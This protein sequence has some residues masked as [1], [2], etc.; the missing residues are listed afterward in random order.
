MNLE[1]SAVTIVASGFLDPSQ[2]S[3]G[4]EF[5]LYAALAGGGQLIELPKIETAEAQI[6]HNSGD[7]AADLIDIY[8]NGELAVD[9]LGFREA[10]PYIELRANKELNIAIAPANTSIDDSVATFSFNLDANEQY[11]MVANGI[12]SNSGYTPDKPFDLDVRSMTRK[13]AN[14]SGN[15][16]IL[17]NH[18][19]TDASVVDITEA[20][21]G[22]L[23]DNLPYGEFDGYVE[24]LTDNYELAVL[25]SSGTDTVGRY[26]A[27]LADNNLEDSAIVVVASG[28]V[29]PSENSDGAEF[30]LYAALASGGDLIKL[31]KVTSTSIAE[32]LE[33]TSIKVFPNPSSNR[34]NV[35]WDASQLNDLSLQ[36]IDQKGQ[37]VR[38]EEQLKSNPATYDIQNLK[39]GIYFIQ[40][41]QDGAPMN[42]K[43]LIKQ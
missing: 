34:I 39:D 22:S 2:N 27:A 14:Q 28:F 24:L 8:A 21:A 5:G 9:S 26:E 37:V 23:V 3:D 11:V 42:I 4:A 33:Q 38:K 35:Q 41:K 43:Q 32:K 20:T 15:T 17:I 16:D 31:P 7:D 19:A 1:D 12:V 40:L 10:T 29:N 13:T 6:I 36:I 30:G 18:G 25:D